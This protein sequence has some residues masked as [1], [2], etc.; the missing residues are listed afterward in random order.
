[1]LPALFHYQVE[2][3][4][5]SSRHPLQYLE[6]NFRGREYR[7][8]RR[9]EG[10]GGEGERREGEKYHN[11]DRIFELNMKGLSAIADNHTKPQYRFFSPY[12]NKI[13]EERREEGI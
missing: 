1:M 3:R 10:R 9:G 12:L 8:G 4:L 7:G 6:K 11:S 5:A 13:R 2:C